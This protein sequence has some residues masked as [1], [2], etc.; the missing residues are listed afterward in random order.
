[1]RKMIAITI[2]VVIVLFLCTSANA[3]ESSDAGDWKFNLAPFY[4]WAVA[5]D[6]EMTTGTTGP[7]PIVA[8]F[9]DIVSG[10]EALFT[11]HFEGMHKVGWG[12]LI[13]AS[14][15]NIGDQQLTP[16]GTLDVDFT[17]VMTEV[18]AVYRFSLGANALDLIGGIRYYSLENDVNLIGF[19]P[20]YPNRV[21][22]SQDWLDAMVGARYIWFIKD[23]WNFKAR[24][25]IGLGGS[26]LSW[27]LAGLFEY[28][29]RKHVSLLAGYRYM[30]IDYEDGSGA[31]LFKYEVTMHGPLLGVNFVW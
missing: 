18:A 14:Y 15:I 3:G 31:D 4:L 21:K 1:M 9:S 20:G 29:P 17:T 22:M 12:F 25:D 6:G 10:L 19:P 16:D 30:S 13:D 27:N 11:V 2:S 8:E 28:Q 23:K 26:D 5:M 7:T 24:G